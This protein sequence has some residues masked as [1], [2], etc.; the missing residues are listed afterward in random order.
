MVCDVDVVT[1]E[2]PFA[3]DKIFARRGMS[4][5]KDDPRQKC[6]KVE[7][8]WD[9]TTAWTGMSRM[10]RSIDKLAETEM[11]GDQTM[12][13]ETRL[14]TPA[15][16]GP[17]PTVVDMSDD[18]VRLRNRMSLGRPVH[19]RKAMETERRDRVAL[20]EESRKLLHLAQDTAKQA[21]QVQNLNVASDVLLSQHEIAEIGR[22]LKNATAE[23][24][25]H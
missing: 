2:T 6:P 14:S 19:N 5:D 24:T 7:M 8:S 17:E 21:S 16:S 13:G 18:V 25:N 11:T 22:A 3:R 15:L 10:K 1:L 23:Y 9:G 12:G 20:D 4:R